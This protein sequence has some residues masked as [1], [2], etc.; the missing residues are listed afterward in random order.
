MAARVP[1]CGPVNRVYE[2][3]VTSKRRAIFATYLDTE[4]DSRMT[5]NR[6]RIE[7][8]LEKEDGSADTSLRAHSLQRA[9]SGTVPTTL[10]PYEWEQWYAEHGVPEAHLKPAPDAP[11]PWWKKWFT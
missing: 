7:R 9:T 1:L 8:L 3:T 10:T 6:S 11:L 5:D 2:S 4:R